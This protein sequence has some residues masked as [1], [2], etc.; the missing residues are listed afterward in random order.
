MEQFVITSHSALDR[1]ALSDRRSTIFCKEHQN[2]LG[3]LRASGDV[4]SAQIGRENMSDP[5]P[6]QSNHHSHSV[7]EDQMQ[8]V[9]SGTSLA[10]AAAPARPQTRSDIF[11]ISVITLFPL[12]TP[13]LRSYRLMP[14]FFFL[15]FFS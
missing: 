4:S 10:V 12:Y 9:T 11:V 6:D 13:L 1:G 15:F 2:V 5:V 8:T 3:L 7:R 14:S